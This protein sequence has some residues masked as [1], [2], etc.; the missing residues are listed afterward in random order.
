MKNYFQVLAVTAPHWIKIPDEVF[1]I[2]LNSLEPFSLQ[3]AIRLALS[4]AKDEKS[5]WSMSN[6]R[7]SE[8]YKKSIMLYQDF[9]GQ[10]SDYINRLLEIKPNLLIISTM[11]LGYSGAIKIASIAKDILGNNVF[12]ILGGKH[13]IETVY[14]QNDKIELNKSCPL[15]HM[16]NG[17]IPKIFDLVI[18]GDGEELIYYIGEIISECTYGDFHKAFFE[19]L[20]ILENANG[21]WI[22]GYIDQYENV[23]HL[24]KNSI[25]DQDKMP[26][27]SEFFIPKSNFSVFETD[28]TFHSYSYM[29]KGCLHDCFYCSERI[30]INGKYKQSETAPDR[31]LKQFKIIQKY[32]IENSFRAS[33]FIEDSIL[34]GGK[35]SLLKKFRDLLKK[36][37][38][39]IPFGGQFTIDLLLNKNYQL[40]LNELSKLG[41]SYIFIGVETNVQ[42]IANLMNKNLNDKIDWITKIE[43]VIEFLS[44]ININC[45]FSLLF[46]LG[47]NHTDRINILNQ[48][49]QWQKKYFQPKIISL[50]LATLHPLRINKDIDFIEWGT[51]VDS[52]FL[53]VF[54]EIFGE[55]SEKYPII[56]DPIIGSLNELNEI[57]EKYKQI[58][59]RY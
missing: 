4:K 55:A 44:S 59:E 29:S 21:H 28:L 43:N 58:N 1:Q 19:N 16:K 54:T 3:N 50:N 5:G 18:S 38:F 17:I 2:S 42:R 33:A 13:I 37:E 14:L 12:V 25:I 8:S 47:E 7:H 34:L 27:P 30:S 49:V 41:L 56:N 57:R 10:K 45:G 40:I 9:E 32:Q 39:N 46:G 48:I 22:I 31:L 53:Q 24:S 36:H 15:Y 35:I 26:F 11:T 51:N 20:N 23:K 6:W 52:A